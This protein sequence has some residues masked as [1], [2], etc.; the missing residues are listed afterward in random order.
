MFLGLRGKERRRGKGIEI[1]LGGGGQGPLWR[2]D[3]RISGGLRML[4]RVG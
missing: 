4:R 3:A 1:L 2:C